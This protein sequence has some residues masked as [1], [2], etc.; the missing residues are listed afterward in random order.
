VSEA[1]ALAV[2]QQL[3]DSPALTAELRFWMVNVD[4][5]LVLMR[6]IRAYAESLA[7]EALAESSKN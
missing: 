3:R 4:N 1:E 5:G 2:L 6:A 7:R